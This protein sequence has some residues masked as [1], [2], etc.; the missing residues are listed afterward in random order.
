LRDIYFGDSRFAAW[1]LSV[2]GGVRVGD[3]LSKIYEIKDG[4]PVRT[5]DVDKDG[6]VQYKIYPKTDSPAYICV[7]DGKI[8][9]ISY[10]DPL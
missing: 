4:D 7:K 10:S 1:T 5:E 2:D 6:S 9:W 8:T 3:N